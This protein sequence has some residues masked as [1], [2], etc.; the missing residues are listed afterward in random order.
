MRRAQALLAYLGF[1]FLVY[2]SV[3]QKRKTALGLLC[4]MA[5]HDPAGVNA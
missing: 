2:A 4:A 3:N 1:S 5:W